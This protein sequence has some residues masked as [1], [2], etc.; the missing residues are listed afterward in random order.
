MLSGISPRILPVQPAETNA[1]LE[2][3]SVDLHNYQ[4]RGFEKK[5]N[6]VYGVKGDTCYK[7][8][9]FFVGAASYLDIEMSPLFS[10]KKAT[11]GSR[12]GSAIRK[13]VPRRVDSLPGSGSSAN[14]GTS[15]M[16]RL[17]SG[18]TL[19]LSATL[20]LFR[21]NSEDRKFVFDLID[22]LDGY[23]QPAENEGSEP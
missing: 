16:V 21:L 12:S 20:D 17:Q 2:R 5:M 11:N 9:R 8:V 4:S 14:S 3:R 18:G 22:K 7:A 6:E 13:R 10:G 1:W 19:T 15:K 23:V